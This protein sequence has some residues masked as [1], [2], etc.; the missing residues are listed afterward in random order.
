MQ[1]TRCRTR[2]GVIRK[3]KARGARSNILATPGESREAKKTKPEHQDQ[4]ESKQSKTTET[5]AEASGSRASG[6][7]APA[8]QENPM[9]GDEVK[10]IRDEDVIGRWMPPGGITPQQQRERRGLHV[11]DH[12]VKEEP[13]E[14]KLRI[15]AMMEVHRIEEQEVELSEQ[16]ADF[17]ELEEQIVSG[18]PFLPEEKAVAL[19]VEEN[20]LEM[21]NTFKRVSREECPPGTRV[22]GTTVV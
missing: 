16:K 5:Y 22:L 3:K 12:D 19:E 6:S 1:T 13:E 2:K 10:E 9:E 14:T 20:K 11:E 18:E 17:G 7:S 21:N 4:R 8:A 15:V